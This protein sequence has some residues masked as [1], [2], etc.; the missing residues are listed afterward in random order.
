M[1]QT[2]RLLKRHFLAVQFASSAEGTCTALQ[3]FAKEVAQLALVVP[4]DK[5]DMLCKSIS[6][7]RGVQYDVDELRSCCAHEWLQQ[8][9][10]ACGKRARASESTGTLPTLVAFQECTRSSDSLFLEALTWV[11]ERPRRCR[12][13]T[14]RSAERGHRYAGLLCRSR[15]WGGHARADAP[16]VIRLLE[17]EQRGGSEGNP[18]LAD[19]CLGCCYYESKATDRNLRV[20]CEYFRSSAERGF[21]PAQFAFAQCA[22]QGKGMS[23]DMGLAERWMQMSAA[24]QFPLAQLNLVSFHMKF[25]KRKPENLRRMLHLTRSIANKGY[26]TA[27]LNLACFYY[28]GMGIPKDH[29]LAAEWLKRAAEQGLGEAVYRLGVMLAKGDGVRRDI[30][31]AR[32]LLKRS[33]NP[34]AHFHLAKCAELLQEWPTAAQ[35]Y[36]IAAMHRQADAQF[37]LACLLC[38]GRGV[39]VDTGSALRWSRR[40]AIRGHVG[41]QYYMAMHCDDSTER[42]DWLERAAE[43]GCRKARF[44]LRSESTAHLK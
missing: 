16:A 44:R 8:N 40:A 36:Q 2:T 19:Y 3:A 42:R 28:W 14:E 27:Q 6:S 33:R 5:L 34:R 31:S 12:R 7:V 24:Q 17:A 26:R 15:G 22:S 9:Q 41:A 21:A 1:C 39:E 25:L 43:Q 29:S 4:A 32:D 20:A 11:V 30:G 13:L 18:M 38:T 10:K 37:E 23:V 35:E